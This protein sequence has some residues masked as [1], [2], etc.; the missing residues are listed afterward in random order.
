MANNLVIIASYNSL[1]EAELAKSFLDENNIEAFIV[2]EYM[3][4]I[5]PSVNFDQGDL[6][7]Q[8]AEQDAEMAAHL[9]ESVTDSYYTQ[10]MLEDSG[11]IL[12]GHFQLTSGRHSAEYIEKIKIIQDPEKVSALCDKLSDRLAD[13][14]AEIVIGPAYGGIVLAYEVAKQLGLKFAFTQRK[15]EKMVLRNGFKLVP[16]TRALIIEDIVTTGNSVR[17]VISALEEMEI[18]VAAIGVIV[19]RSGHSVDF[20]IPTEVLLDMEI[21]TYDPSEC[22]LCAKGMMLSK[23]GSSDKK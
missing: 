21:A 9:L 7:I 23:P 22:P 1:F 20:G 16:G 5:L 8:V 3:G 19:D 18:E 17:E 12:H 11:A 2:N 14:G 15:D 6:S 13:C 10:K 4:S